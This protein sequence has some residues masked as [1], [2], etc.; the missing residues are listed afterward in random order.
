M[1]HGHW[2]TTTFVASLLLSGVA[3]PFVLD[4][5]ANQDIEALKRKAA[6][7]SVEGLWSPIG[8]PSTLSHPMNTQQSLSTSGYHSNDP[9]NAPGLKD[10]Y[11]R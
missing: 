8:R 10:E 5:P 11:N 2:K 7:R 1:P 6:P 3:A 9:E 4:G